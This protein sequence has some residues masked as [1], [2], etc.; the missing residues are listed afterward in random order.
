[1]YANNGRNRRWH[2]DYARGLANGQ[3]SRNAE[4]SE[5]LPNTLG[6]QHP[7][8]LGF[9]VGIGMREEKRHREELA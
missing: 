5:V 8:R 7:Y 3:C 2:R 4:R 6:A 1:M 9:L